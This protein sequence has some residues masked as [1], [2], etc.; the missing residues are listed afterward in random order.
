MSD[1]LLEELSHD[2]FQGMMGD[3]LSDDF[4][5][6]SVTE[7]FGA[8]AAMDEAESEV[9]SQRPE[10]RGQRSDVDQDR[11]S[12]SFSFTHK[13]NRVSGETPRFLAALR[14]FF[15]KAFSTG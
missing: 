7:F 10:M 5:K 8:L 12:S 2:E 14:I 1:T 9:G 13:F 4:D 6:V 15:D 3:L 11:F